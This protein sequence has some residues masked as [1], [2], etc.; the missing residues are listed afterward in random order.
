[1]QRFNIGDRVE[2]YRNPVVIHGTI[3]KIAAR[4]CGERIAVEWD[5][6]V[7]GH[8]VTWIEASKLHKIGEGR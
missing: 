7:P 8:H 5:D 1:M 4:P 3:G 6:P 2:T